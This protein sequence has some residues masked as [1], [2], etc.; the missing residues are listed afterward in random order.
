MIQ[1]LSRRLTC[2]F[3]AATGVILTL[4]LCVAFFYQFRLSRIQNEQA[5]QNQLLE[6]THLLEGT[7]SFSDNY[8]AKLENDGHLIIHIEDNQRPIFFS[9]SWEPLTERETLINLANEKALAEN[10]DTTNPP[11][12]R[13]LH[14]SSVFSLKGRH[15]DSY[16]GTVLVISTENGFRSLTLLADTTRQ[17]RVF[18]FQCILFCLLELTGILALFFVSRH[19]V[20]KA[21]RPI[22]EYHQRQTDFVAA[23]SHELRSPLAV[24]QTSASA[25][26]AA[27]EQAPRMVQIIQKECIRSASLIKN[28]LLLASADA[29]SLTSE[30]Q[31]VEIDTL[32][33]QLFE[34]YQPLCKSRN[35]HL[36]LVLPD[37]FLPEV[38]GNAQWIYQILSILLDNA[39]AY[40]CPNPVNQSNNSSGVPTDAHS[41]QDSIKK[42]AIRLTAELQETMVTLSVIDYGPGISDEQKSLI[43]DRFYRADTSRT[44]KEHTGLGL[45]IARALAEQM[46]QPLNVTDTESGGCTF[47]INF[48]ICQTSKAE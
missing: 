9:G 29:G 13:S 39:I 33:L 46:N 18:L 1:K 12:S 22:E 10:I 35:I 11:F 41:S 40:G 4:V 24:I 45:S 38:Y 27:P 43:F 42:P 37:E 25:V 30:M 36:Q 34:N 7:T 32:L 6:L 14:K 16:Q 31:S 5:F 47:Q 44:D 21:V 8:L 17:H 23:A 15:G 26:S 28:L 3:T 48:T 2:L 20:Q 19:V